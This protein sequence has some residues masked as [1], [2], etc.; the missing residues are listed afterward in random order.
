[1]SLLRVFLRASPRML[2]LAVI[3]GV[4]AG[5]IGAALISEVNSALRHG[6]SAAS[7]GSSRAFAYCACSRA[8]SWR[9]Q[10]HELAQRS[11]HD[12]R[13]ELVNVGP[14]RSPPRARE[15]RC[16]EVARRSDERRGSDRRRR[17]LARGGARPGRVCAR[18]RG[19]LCWLRCRHLWSCWSPFWP[20]WPC[21]VGSTVEAR[22]TSSWA[23]KLG[24]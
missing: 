13:M 12:L 1:M 6:G 2:I 23:A 22:V 3:L 19:Y 5:A 16:L 18:M 15:G 11:I 20:A 9:L 10:L 17:T 4:V 8:C 7:S 21:N 24:T 14:E